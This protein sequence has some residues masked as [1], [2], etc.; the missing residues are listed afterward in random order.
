MKNFIRFNAL[1]L[2]CLS[3]TLSAAEIDQYTT[4]HLDLADASEIVNNEANNHVRSALTRLEAVGCNED[5]LYVELRKAF[6]NHK[7]GQLTIHM[8]H[9]E[10]FPRSVIPL[11]ESI[12]ADWNSWDGYLLG[13]PAAAKSPLALGPLVNIDGIRVGTDKFEHLFGRGFMYF[14]RHYLKGHSLKRVF[15]FGIKG[16]KTIF[17]GNKLATGIFSYADLSSNFNGMRFWNHMLQLRDDVM[18]D[19]HGPYIEC[20]DNRY[21]QV[22]PID[23]RHYMDESMDESIN[24]PKFATKK[25]M[26]KYLKR[27]EALGYTCP[28][29]K[30]TLETMQQKYGEFSHWII[31]EEGPGKVK[32][33]GEFRK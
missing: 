14:K 27:V 24:C 29:S 15:K 33:F 22:K 8:L 20:Q 17:G 9:A 32:Y 31:N 1:L 26:N 3:I 30:Q 10:D 6:S 5:S 18:G 19:N 23:F 21:V 28:M 11:R 7:D 13:R 12:Y 25:T 4:R 2:G 16:E